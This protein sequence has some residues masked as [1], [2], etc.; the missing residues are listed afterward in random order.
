MG[1]RD[2]NVPRV[3]YGYIRKCVRAT[4]LYETSRIRDKHC[5]PEHAFYKG[6]SLYWVMIC[7]AGLRSQCKTFA[8]DLTQTPEATSTTFGQIYASTIVAMMVE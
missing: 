8:S 1:I 5:C 7:L 6:V 4:R 2:T 3:K